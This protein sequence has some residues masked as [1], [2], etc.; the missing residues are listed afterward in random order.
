MN[1]GSS[2][3]SKSEATDDAF[4]HNNEFIKLNSVETFWKLDQ[5]HLVLFETETFNR[6]GDVRLRFTSIHSTEEKFNALIIRSNFKRYF[7][8]FNGEIIG[9]NGEVI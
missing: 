3:Y 4:W 7:G 2:S 9:N 1:L 8:Y 5:S 6:P